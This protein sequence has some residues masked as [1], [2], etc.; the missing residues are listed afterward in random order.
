MSLQVG[1]GLLSRGMHDLIYVLK[2]SVWLTRKW[3]RVGGYKDGKSLFQKEDI[4]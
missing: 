3:I 2:T 4:Q 1:R